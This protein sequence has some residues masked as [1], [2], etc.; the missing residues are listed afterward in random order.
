[1]APRG[2]FPHI[3]GMEHRL[4]TLERAFEL[5]RSGTCAD[6]AQV[7]HQLKIEGYARDQLTGPALIR[8]I[9]DL[10]IAAAPKSEA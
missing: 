4:T 3:M 8:Q 1:M 5:A 6:V 9:R 10:C 7:R 2:D